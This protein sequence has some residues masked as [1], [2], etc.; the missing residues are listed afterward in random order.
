MSLARRFVWTPEAVSSTIEACKQSRSSQE[1][2]QNVRASLG[3]DVTFDAIQG[4]LKRTGHQ[5]MME[6]LAPP[7]TAHRPLTP[8]PIPFPNISLN[9]PTWGGPQRTETDRSYVDR[10]VSKKTASSELETWLIWSD[11]HCPFENTEAFDLVLKVGQSIKPYGTAVIGDFLDGLSVSSHPKAPEQIRVQLKDEVEA[12][13]KRLDQIDALGC[14][15]KRFYAGNHDIRG[16]RAAMRQM[17][18]LYDSL[19]PDHLLRLK[20]RGWDFFKYQQHAP[21]GKINLIHDVGY[22]GKYAAYANGAAFEASVMCG[23]SHRASLTYFGNV[24]GERHV[25]AT[26]GWL[27]S[28]EAADYLAPIK[29]TRDWQTSFALIWNDR[30]RD[31][32]HIQIIPIIEGTCVVN[33]VLYEA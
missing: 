28:Q 16:Q 8:P 14:T 29:S 9:L 2:V 17:I 22:S 31:L 4:A 3:W 13:N 19:S 1:A 27:G 32:S 26:I 7:E 30:E 5:G 12:G 33:G 6:L 10:S 25:S 24:K 20:D 21:I 23:H 18:G 11:V 15:E